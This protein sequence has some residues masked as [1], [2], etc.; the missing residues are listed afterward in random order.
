M[1]VMHRSIKFRNDDVQ[2]NWA[3]EVNNSN[4]RTEKERFSDAVKFVRKSME[5][6]EE[7]VF[8]PSTSP[9]KN[10]LCLQKKGEEE[11]E[12][13][14]SGRRHALF[15]RGNCLAGRFFYDMPVEKLKK[16]RAITHSSTPERPWYDLCKEMGGWG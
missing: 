3:L 4:G 15:A 12:V 5:G 6:G 7:I 11:Y 13:V 1:S 2:W 10:E 9:N 14:F 16:I 8:S